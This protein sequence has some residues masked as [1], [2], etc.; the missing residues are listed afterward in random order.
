MPSERGSARRWASAGPPALFWASGLELWGPSLWHWGP[1]CAH[2]SSAGSPAC[3][4][5]DAERGWEGGRPLPAWNLPGSEVWDVMC[6]W[7]R[8]GR[9]RGESPHSSLS[10]SG[11]SSSSPKNHFEDHNIHHELYYGRL[12]FMFK[13]KCWHPELYL[14]YGSLLHIN[15][16]KGQLLY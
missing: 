2:C 7:S 1:C 3:C 13:N 16:L 12:F 4:C 15:V 5:Q 9:P 8:R 14:V 11:C 10:P 6:L